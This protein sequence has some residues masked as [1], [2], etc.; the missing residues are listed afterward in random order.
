MDGSILIWC[1]DPSC[2]HCKFYEIFISQS[3]TVYIRW[4]SEKEGGGRYKIGAKQ[5]TTSLHTRHA[6]TTVNYHTPLL[7]G[8]DALCGYYLDTVSPIVSYN[9]HMTKY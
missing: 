8:G 2:V 7:C 4:R 6:P 9:T 3:C 5:H 1:I